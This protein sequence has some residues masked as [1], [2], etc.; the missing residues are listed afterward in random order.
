[1]LNI[2]INQ[3]INTDRDNW[4]ELWIFSKYRVGFHYFVN[5]ISLVIWLILLLV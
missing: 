2:K 5:R 4:K 1:M 3:V